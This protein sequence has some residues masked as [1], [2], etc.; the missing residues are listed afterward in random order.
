MT[1]RPPLHYKRVLFV[2]AILPMVFVAAHTLR[3]GDS[4]TIIQ[5]DL[6]QP[7]FRTIQ[8]SDDVAVHLVWCQPHELDM[9]KINQMNP[10]PSFF[11]PL[12]PLSQTNGF[13][14]GQ[15]EVSQAQWNEVARKSRFVLHKSLVGVRPEYLDLTGRNPMESCR[16]GDVEIFLTILN[17]VVTNLHFRL[18]TEEEWI[19]AGLADQP[20][21]DTNKVHLYAWA[22]ENSG[23]KRLKN[24]SEPAEAVLAG[25]APHP[26][27]TKYANA[28]GLYDMLGNVGEYCERQTENGIQ[29]V[30]CGGC[31][32]DP[33]VACSVFNRLELEMPYEDFADSTT[34]FRIVAEE[35]VSLSTGDNP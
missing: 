21:L 18:P 17:A 13:W 32:L 30:V 25:C 22:Y 29:Y 9:S 8:L 20:P 12:P 27:G 35:L 16:V 28:F 34:G 24:I 33:L 7:R 1:S 3:H 11:D 10:D 26:V 19:F 31:W 4:Q 14:I 2:V 23:K 15:T 5:A 6:P